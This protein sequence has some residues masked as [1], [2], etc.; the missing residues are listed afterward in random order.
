MEDKETS[1]K[2]LYLLDGFSQNEYNNTF[3]NDDNDIVIEN[4]PTQTIHAVGNDANTNNNNNYRDNNNNHNITTTN[5]A[6]INRSIL[7][8]QNSVISIPSTLQR[9]IDLQNEQLGIAESQ[10]DTSHATTSSINNNI[11]Q[12][13]RR[14]SDSPNMT[15]S[16]SSV[17]SLTSI[18][19]KRS[20]FK[21]AKCN[22][23]DRIN[24]N[25]YAIS[26]LLKNLKKNESDS[27]KLGAK[28]FEIN[29]LSIT[30]LSSEQTS[31]R[32]FHNLSGQY[33]TISKD[34]IPTFY[35]S[36]EV[37]KS[38]IDFFNKVSDI[39]QKYGCIK[40]KIIND[41][42]NNSKF[43]SSRIPD[44][45]KEKI[46]FENFSF[47]C[48]QQKL[49]S[50]KLINRSILSFYHDLYQFYTT[51][52]S[53][54]SEFDKLPKINSKSVSLYSLYRLVQRN[55]GFEKVEKDKKW[56]FIEKR[57][58]YTHNEEEKVEIREFYRKFLLNFEQSHFA[59]T[60]A[61]KDKHTR[62]VNK[63]KTKDTIKSVY[64]LCSIGNDY[65]RIKDMK[66]VKH[67]NINGRT[68]TDIKNS[69]IREKDTFVSQWQSWFPLYDHDK[70]VNLTTRT[71]NVEE[72][73]NLSQEIF[74][75]IF[76]K[77]YNIFLEDTH[78]IQSIDITQFEEFYFDILESD[79]IDLT[80][81]TGSRLSSANH[82]INL[83]IP[84]S[85][86]DNLRKKYD[87][88]NLA[89]V[90]LDSQSC[91]RY[92]NFDKGDYTS[93]KYDLG[94]LCSVSG[95]SINDTYLPSVDYQHIGAPKIWYVIPP[96]DMEK[97][98]K[99]LQSSYNSINY[100][101]PNLKNKILN[102]SKFVN[103]SIYKYLKNDEIK[104]PP[105]TLID[106]LSTYENFNFADSS[107]SKKME[108][109]V[110]IDQQLQI[111]P[112]HLRENGIKVYRIF[113]ESGSYIFK[114]PKCYSSTLGSDFYFSESA[115]FLP[116]S[117][118]FGYLKEGSHWLALNNCLP[119]INYTSLLTNIIQSSND[120][121]LVEKAKH[122]LSGIIKVELN[123]RSQVFKYF[124]DLQVIEN[125]FDFISDFTLKPTGF[126][127]IE[128]K[129]KSTRMTLSLAEFLNNLELL[130]NSDWVLFDVPLSNMHVSVHLY[131]QNNLLLSLIDS[132]D[133][134]LISSNT[135]DPLLSMTLEEKIS[136]MLVEKYDNER[137]PLNVIEN[138][139]EE[140]TVYDNYYYSVKDLID[141]AYLLINQ[142]KEILFQFNFN[143]ELI[144]P[145]LEDFEKNPLTVLNE[146]PLAMIVSKFN[147]LV[148]TL[149]QSSITSPEMDYMIQLYKICQEFKSKVEIA[150]ASNKL[151]LLE[152]AYLQSFEIPLD[153]AY[154]QILIRSICRFKWSDIYYE[155]FTS[156]DIS[157]SLIARSLTFLYDFWNYGINFCQEE[158]V[159]K[160]I[161]VKE[162][163]LLCQEIFGKIQMIIDKSRKHKMIS[164][165]DIDSIVV[166]I[167]KKRLPIPI[168]LK[169]TLTM[170]SGC[171]QDTISK[172][173]PFLSQLAGNKQFIDEIDS[174]IRGNSIKSFEYFPRFNGSVE[175]TRINIK[176]AQ[177]K[178]S[179]ADGIAD[180]KAWYSELRRITNGQSIGSI[181]KSA[182]KTL[183]LTRDKYIESE[184][185]SSFP[186]A[187]YCL[188]R[189]EEGGKTM[190]QCD[191]CKEWYHTTCVGGK[192]WDFSND[193]N[194]IFVCPICDINGNTVIHKPNAVNFGDLKRNILDIVYLDVI[195]D[196]KILQ[197]YFELYKIALIFRNSMYEAL[198]K[199]GNINQD[200]PIS[201]IKY[202]LKKAEK[203]KIEF[204]DL[205]GPL[206]RYCH[207]IDKTQY[208]FY[209]KTKKTII[210]V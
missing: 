45:Y 85:S 56:E 133:N 189:E 145:N 67:L 104:N 68:K 108:N 205:V 126:S 97:F 58:N 20:L 114:Y 138:L 175:D 154:C 155:L 210:T 40:L 181:L 166:Q 7:S 89:N 200:V 107:N 51:N 112:S 124:P 79:N 86:S 33:Y 73:F 120:H 123:E 118:S 113:Q 153:H 193:E 1:D 178:P 94:M 12:R 32:L 195:P 31:E 184:T 116:K 19:E 143:L 43:N 22:T 141:K 206:K 197:Q 100:G 128:I 25:Q 71:F 158:D 135:N 134:L 35:V 144:K 16:N 81:F 84:Q 34:S 64:E 164:I 207:S 170:I 48:R 111:R 54:D 11:M 208:E 147:Q 190:I 53:K 17:S 173:N 3:A 201:L 82:K 95:W 28:T 9:A 161:K 38:P 150:I 191:I 121:Y 142:C 37:F 4:S 98:E 50:R 106:R 15:S 177:G 119:G 198:F 6:N 115:Y 183:D 29:T 83:Q 57:L 176:E 149:M 76:I 8:Q 151:K 140:T 109:I 46:N 148:E 47:K 110:L 90:P 122:D 203:S 42:D 131:Y 130:D 99:Y 69:Q 132:P 75:E 187:L 168:N 24:N 102:D 52:S 146:S 194:T 105:Y 117:I 65:P 165:E 136:M 159:P 157:D 66:I 49:T 77:Y 13:K 10:N 156:F 93:S 204:I 129:Y 127:K 192:D 72:Y 87:R 62:L 23:T 2:L 186:E 152:K 188:C 209:T 196:K 162:R 61:Y 169:R 179:L 88:W 171:I 27:F 5:D 44:S 60:H 92:L 202:Y 21:M 163:I 180:Y 167:D 70:Y 172:E 14:L 26:D 18:N 185:E 41:D 182:K 59:I 101:K 174:Y 78:N 139:L 80:I 39:G 63:G 91:F 160:L 30:D 199:D 74:Q 96:E 36:K 103:S 125:R 137:I 55:G